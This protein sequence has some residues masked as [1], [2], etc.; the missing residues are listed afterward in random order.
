MPLIAEAASIT[1]L[2]CFAVTGRYLRLDTKA[3]AHV[4][5]IPHDVIR[6]PRVIEQ[7]EMD[8]LLKLRLFAGEVQG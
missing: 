4:F 5:H 6:T 8:A 3:K 1:R 7:I 2:F